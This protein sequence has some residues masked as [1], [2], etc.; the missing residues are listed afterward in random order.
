MDARRS[1]PRPPAQHL[2]RTV[3]EGKASQYTATEMTP[4]CLTQSGRQP[5]GTMAPFLLLVWAGGVLEVYPQRGLGL[6]LADSR[7][8]GLLGVRG[9]QIPRNPLVLH[10][11]WG[12]LANDQT[13]QA[14]PK[15]I[16]S[17]CARGKSSAGNPRFPREASTG[18][19]HPQPDTDPS[20]LC[21]CSEALILCRTAKVGRE[22][23]SPP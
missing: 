16:C 4:P 5:V 15:H 6:R 1:G 19:Q 9:R 3:R 7:E 17:H 2:D 12:D 13:S 10:R 8:P 11:S 23:E 20:Q 22:Q 14:F 18:C 21:V